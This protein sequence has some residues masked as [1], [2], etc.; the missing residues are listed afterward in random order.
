MKNPAESGGY[1]G[2]AGGNKG[3][4]KNLVW[5]ILDD[6]SPFIVDML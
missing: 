3:L 2:Q 6:R 1:N 4:E 5:L